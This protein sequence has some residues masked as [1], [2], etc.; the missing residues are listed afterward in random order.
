ME[1]RR[2]DQ[3][4]AE[5][6]ETELMPEMANAGEDHRHV[7]LVCGG[8]DFLVANRAARL[9]RAGRAGVGSRDQAVWKREESIA[10]NRAAF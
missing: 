3:F 10:R 9:D 5:S 1:Y 4:S 6:A 2:A 8:D 7:A